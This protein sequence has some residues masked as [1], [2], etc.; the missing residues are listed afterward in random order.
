[1]S[2]SAQLNNLQ[3]R[4]ADN[5]FE[6]NEDYHYPLQCFFK[7]RHQKIP[8]LIIEGQQ[9]RRKTAFAN[10]LGRALQPAHFFYY[11][12]AQQEAAEGKVDLPPSKDEDGVRAKPVSD[13][14]FI[15]SE[16]CAHSEADPTILVLDQLHLTDFK[17]HI[18]LYHF[19]NDFNWQSEQISLRANPDNFVLMLISSEVIYH[20]LQKSGYRIWIHEVNRQAAN[21]QPQDF[22]LDSSFEPVFKAMDDLFS[23]LGLY[24]S[25]SE[26]KHIVYDMQ[27]HVRDEQQLVYS[28]Y[29]WTEN[30]ALDMLQHTEVQPLIRQIIA[31]LHSWLGVDE[32]IL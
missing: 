18:R 13:F 26:L 19:V 11:D 28:I 17:N 24:P 3:Q 21:Y 2:F 7:A 14:N 10:A 16:A 29:G 6:S 30:I 4:L 27:W 9:Q 5:G 22:G 15:M 12:F 20:S 8:L 32:V 25:L 23:E 1:M 31:S